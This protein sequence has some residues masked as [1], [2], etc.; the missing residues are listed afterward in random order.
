MLLLAAMTMTGRS[1]T[2]LLTRDPGFEPD[3]LLTFRISPSGEAYETD[4]QILSFYER[5]IQRLNQAPGIT[6]AAVNSQLPMGGI[7][8]A[9]R[10]SSRADRHSRRLRRWN[11]TS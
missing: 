6:S 3:H 8:T 10:S 2:I 1:L 4:A 5:L 7:T 9:S 11:V